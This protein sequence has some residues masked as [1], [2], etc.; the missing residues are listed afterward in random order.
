M[1]VV[2]VC[3]LFFPI[4][5]QE[6]SPQIISFPRPGSTFLIPGEMKNLSCEII[7]KMPKSLVR[8]Q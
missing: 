3:W 7:G 2:D 5:K 4:G 6:Q 1:A 8:F